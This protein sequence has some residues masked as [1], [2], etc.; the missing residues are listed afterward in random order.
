MK[1]TL[2]AY[3]FAF[4]GISTLWANDGV[5]FTSGSF[6]VPT[7]ETDISVV[8][9]ILTITI[10]KDSMARVDVFYELKNNG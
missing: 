8:K 10:G 1:R 6:L 2:I 7:K 9:E 4:L 3:L 5:Y